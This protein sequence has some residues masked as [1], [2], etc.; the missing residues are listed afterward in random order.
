MEGAEGFCK[1]RLEVK[2]EQRNKNHPRTDNVCYRSGANTQR[3]DRYVMCAC[4]CR[5]G[6]IAV[7]GTNTSKKSAVK[8]LAALNF[9]L[10]DKEQHNKCTI[11]A[12]NT[13]S[14]ST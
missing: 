1:Q 11:K 13:D 14:S 6:N 5:K 4:M 2:S 10:K 12:A 7:T 3:N 8:M 9:D